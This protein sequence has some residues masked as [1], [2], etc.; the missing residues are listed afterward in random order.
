MK[1]SV[2]K[3]KPSERFKAVLPHF[4]Q[5]FAGN[6]W[7]LSQRTKLHV[8]QFNSTVSKSRAPCALR[9]TQRICRSIEFYDLCRRIDRRKRIL[10]SSISTYSPFVKCRF[11]AACNKKIKVFHRTVSLDV[12]STWQHRVFSWPNYSYVIHWVFLSLTYS[13]KALFCR[14]WFGHTVS[15]TTMTWSWIGGRRYL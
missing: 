9:S 6:H 11:Y 10:A 1:F 8:I 7:R 5:Y 12:A 2:R 15:E 14:R 3:S 4:A 13:R